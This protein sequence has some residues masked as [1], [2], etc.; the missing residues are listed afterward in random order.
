MEQKTITKDVVVK[1]ALDLAARD[2]WARVRLHDIAAAAGI[3]LVDIHDKFADK[4]DILIAL[5]RMIDRAVLDNVDTDE[6]APAHE[7]LFDILMDRFEVL[8]EHRA[9]IIAILQSF[10]TAPKNA[11]ISLPHLARSMSWMM[12][13]A[14]IDTNG[15]RGAIKLAGV[16]GLYLKTLRTWGND[17]SADLSAVMAVLDSGLKKSCDYADMLGL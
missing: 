1:H 7:R 14:H 6:T 2:G 9:G 15:I 11:V 4:T 17:D 8:N 13:A 12:D 10:K 3:S 5:G 16:T